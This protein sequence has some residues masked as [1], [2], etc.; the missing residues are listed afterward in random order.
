[1]GGVTAAVL[2]IDGGNSKTDVCLLSA[3]GQLLGYARGHGSNHQIVGLDTAFD[4]LAGLVAEAR[5]EAGIDAGSRSLS[6]PRSTSPAPISQ[7]R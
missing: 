6:S 7:G 1:V 3:D 4:V 5:V 2:A